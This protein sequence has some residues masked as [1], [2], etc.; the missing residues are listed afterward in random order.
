M[1]SEKTCFKCGLRLSLS[2][3]YKHP[4]MAD[5][6]LGK[7]KLCTRTDVRANYALRADKYR[8]YDKRRNSDPTRRARALMAFKAS[9][10]AAPERKRAA[11]AVASAIRSGKLIP[12]PCHICGE[13]AQAHHPDYS[14]PLDVVWLCLPHH[15]QA[16]AIVRRM[17]SF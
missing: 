13:K 5:G 8:E 1:A 12:H 6:H 17:E 10:M 3:F 15:R 4:A 9:Q 14:R 16:H 2:A 11:D 7:C